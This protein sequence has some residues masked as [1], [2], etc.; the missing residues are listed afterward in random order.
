MALY[1]IGFGDGQGIFEF[2]A[3]IPDCTVHLGMARQE[4][5]RSEVAGFL[6][7]LGDFRAPH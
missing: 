4:L 1:L 5:D 2:D 7:D 6:V 3:G